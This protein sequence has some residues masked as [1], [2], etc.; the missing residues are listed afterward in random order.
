SRRRS[1]RTSGSG[2]TP[3]PRPSCLRRGRPLSVRS[4]PAP[5]Q[6]RQEEPEVRGT[7]REPAREIWVPLRAVRDVDPDR[8]PV[9]SELVLEIPPDTV[10]HL[11]LHLRPSGTG[12][13]DRPL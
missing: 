13:D 9:P 10:K 8:V 6:I 12:G 3:A 7:L 11:E 4:S 2:P 5:R 1:A